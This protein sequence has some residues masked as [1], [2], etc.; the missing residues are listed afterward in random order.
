MSSYQ[1]SV[2]LIVDHPQRDLAGIVLTG[3]QLCQSGVICHLVPH[4][5][6]AQQIWALTPDLV[7]L[8]FFRVTNQDLARKLVRAGIQVAVL[9]TEG[10]VFPDE[11]S[12]TEALCQDAELRRQLGCICMWGPR[13]AQYVV[14]NGLL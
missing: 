6:E 1:P 12:Y 10:G 7:L 9:D 2:A 4:N 5:L 13:L 3:F 8:N 11:R 14:A